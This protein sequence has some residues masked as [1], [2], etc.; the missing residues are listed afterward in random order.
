MLNRFINRFALSV[1]MR[2]NSCQKYLPEI[3][4]GGGYVEP[5]TERGLPVREMLLNSTV[6]SDCSASSRTGCPRSG[7]VFFMGELERPLEGAFRALFQLV[8]DRPVVLP[9]Q[10]FGVLCSGVHEHHCPL[11]VVDQSAVRFLW[12]LGQQ[13]VEKPRGFV[14]IA[15]GLQ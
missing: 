11:E 5:P 8:A 10:V 12:N 4:Q 9:D 2:R 15:P 7:S 13:T 1:R 6:A 14:G 3:V